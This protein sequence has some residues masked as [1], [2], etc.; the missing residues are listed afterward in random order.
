MRCE[1]S[2][3]AS[4]CLGVEHC[5]LLKV[6]AL[7]QKAVQYILLTPP[8]TN[9]RRVVVGIVFIMIIIIIIVINLIA[10]L[11]HVPDRA[12]RSAGLLDSAPQTLDPVRTWNKNIVEIHILYIF[13]DQYLLYVENLSFQ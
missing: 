1:P 11:F 10:R 3:Q 4:I 9:F 2:C 12:T 6:L 8:I 7:L 5:D 13:I